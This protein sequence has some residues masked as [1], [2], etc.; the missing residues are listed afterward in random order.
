[1]NRS[2]R[3]FAYAWSAAVSLVLLFT[4]GSQVFAQQALAQQVLA[5]Q[6]L[7][8]QVL[9]Q[10]VLAQQVSGATSPGATSFGA[11]RPEPAGAD[12]LPFGRRK[13]LRR[14]YR[15]AAA[16]ERLPAREQGEAVGR[17]PQGGGITRRVAHHPGKSHSR[18][19]L[20]TNAR[21][22]PEIMCK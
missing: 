11:I 19:S 1:M 10:Q 8:Q 16:D 20:G 21:R 7:A 13:I 2:V 15:Q 22:L 18:F 4:A 3:K 9:A 6:V 17:L 12:G 14:T 5:Q